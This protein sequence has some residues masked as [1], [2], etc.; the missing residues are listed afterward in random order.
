V[1]AAGAVALLAATVPTGRAALD[2]RWGLPP[3]SYAR[4]VSFMDRDPAGADARVLWV[5][6]PALIPGGEGWALRRGV[7]F[8]TSI[9]SLPV[10]ADLWPATGS[11]RAV[12]VRGALNAALDG[13]TTRLGAA[14]ASA[15]VAYV[16]V[17]LTLAPG[18]DT[19]AGP[20]TRDLTGALAEQLD[21]KQVQVDRDLVLYRNDAFDPEAATRAGPPAP[22][23]MRPASA[24]QLALWLVVLALVVRLRFALSPAAT[25]AKPLAHPHVDTVRRPEPGTDA[26]ADRVEVGV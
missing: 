22:D 2:G 16:A 18:E 25:P 20:A 17:P 6:D 8:T 21:L 24:A 9:P 1:V 5:G 10:V 14:L 4:V 15:G 11:A 7:T 19:P 12:P 13:E 26:D 3:T 23:G